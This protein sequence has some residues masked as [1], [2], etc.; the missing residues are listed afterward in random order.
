VQTCYIRKEQEEKYKRT[1]DQ[2]DF[3]KKI[4]IEEQKEST[5]IKEHIITQ[6]NYM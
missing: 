4:G 3:I 5:G 1:G 2:N 6:A